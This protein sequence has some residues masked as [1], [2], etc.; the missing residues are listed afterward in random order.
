MKN[1]YRVIIGHYSQKDSQAGIYTYLVAENDEDV[2]NQLDEEFD[3]S[4]Y[5]CDD[6]EDCQTDCDGDDM[7]KKN[8]LENK[9]DWNKEVSDLYYGASVSK[10]EL[11]KK[12]I[13]EEEIAT[14]K[15]IGI[16]EDKEIINDR[17][18]GVSFC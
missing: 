16:F 4:W 15:S 10:W 6:E 5:D 9:G 12:N 14:L 3:Y 13:T 8:I 7:N 1:L 2:Y 17:K 11:V 18:L